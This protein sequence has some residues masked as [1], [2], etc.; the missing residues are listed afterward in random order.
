MQ[1]AVVGGGPA[2][3]FFALLAKTRD[4]AREVVVL[5][6][7]GPAEALG[8][9]I[10][11]PSSALGS[12]ERADRAAYRQIVDA[13]LEWENVVFSHG[14]DRE[15]VAG[16]H[17]FGIARMTLLDI[18]RRR[19]LE[20]GVRIQLR[21]AVDSWSDIPDADLIVG[22]DGGNSIVRRLGGTTFRPHIAPSSDLHIWL[23]TSKVF[24]GLTFLFRQ[25]DW[26]PFAALAFKF[27][28]TSSTFIVNAPEAAWERADLL[29]W[30]ARDLRSR[31]AAIF[32]ADLGGA[33]IQLTPGADL[34]AFAGLA[35]D[36]WHD[37]RVV[38][39]GDAARSLH[40][41]THA[42][43]RAAFDDADALVDQLDAATAVGPA[44][45]AYERARRPSIM[46]LQAASEKATRWFEGTA[47]RMG[48]SA[49]EL[50]YDYLVTSGWAD[51]A[52]LAER[53]PEFV[54]R[55]EAQRGLRSDG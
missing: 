16:P 49:V 15:V 51:H 19:C 29:L 32:K 28:P 12:V 4:T 41:S 8:G 3:L 46:G 48:L 2:G 22:A 42:S 25:T 37:E 11:L 17:L 39:I 34:R 27:L 24:H 1:I 5:E 33:T 45:D 40:F 13:C 20:A 6:Q 36:C 35:C 14:G 18:L 47:S 31:I 55:W 54:A 43:T 52:R 53:D 38:L 21:T 44:L 7:L 26:G 10:A 9:G 30:N 50:A 23:T